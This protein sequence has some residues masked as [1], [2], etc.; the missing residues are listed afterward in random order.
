MKRSTQ[1]ILALTA[2]LALSASA[3]MAEQRPPAGP[4]PSV[5]EDPGPDSGPGARQREEAR[6]KIEVI[7]IARL[8]EAL[9]LDE[10]T[11]SRFIPAITALDLKRRSSMMDHRLLI[12]ELRKQLRTSPVDTAKLKETIDR[13]TSSQRDMMKL[14]DKELDTAREHL[15]TEQLARYLLFQQDF[16]REVREIISGTRGHGMGMGIGPG[17]GQGRGPGM[18]RQSPAAPAD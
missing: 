6:K 5:E 4:P 14:R 7:R 1:R 12:M 17:R 8:T 3:V 10:K 16:M 2:V 13:Y 11:A 9:K 18:N 15:T